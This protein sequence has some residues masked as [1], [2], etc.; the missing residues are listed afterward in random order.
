M[1]KIDYDKIF[2]AEAQAK[3][4]AKL[5]LHCCCAPCATSVIERVKQNFDVTL[6]YYNPNIMPEEEYFLRAENL[7]KLADIHGLPLVIEEYDNREFL[8]FAIDMKECKEGGARCEKCIKLRLD[9]TLA[10]AKA[11]GFNLFTTTLT[12]S[13]HKNAQ[14]INE[15]GLSV[16]K[17]VYLPADFKKK[18]GFLRST[19]LCRE[20][21]IYRQSYCGCKL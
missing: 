9:K 21:D 12:V 3:R 6:Y 19:E 16:A 20:Y 1:N 13:P 18:N 10:Y 5:L 8:D 4:G 2:E 11:N 15:Y 7:K 14:M 17:G